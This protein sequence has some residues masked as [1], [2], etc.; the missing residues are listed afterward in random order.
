M[1][2]FNRNIKKNSPSKIQRSN[3]QIQAHYLRTISDAINIPKKI[4]P[5]IIIKKYWNLFKTFT[6]FADII[7]SSLIHFNNEL[8]TTQKRATA[9]NTPKMRGSLIIKYVFVF[10]NTVYIF[11]HPL[12]VLLCDY[13][14]L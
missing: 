7:T 12:Q 11:I 8:T 1:Q 9:K 4:I 10:N 6:V 13:G 2:V 5:A 14:Y 3:S